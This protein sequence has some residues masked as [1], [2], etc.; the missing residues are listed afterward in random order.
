MTRLLLLLTLAGCEWVRLPVDDGVYDADDDGWYSVD[1]CD[2]FNDNVHPLAPEKCNGTDNNCSG[3]EDDAEDATTWYADLDGDGYGDAS[4]ALPSCDVP[5]GYVENP[6][7]CDDSTPA[8]HPGA[9]E[10]DCTD[11]VDYDCD[12]FPA[13]WDSDQDGSPDCEDCDEDDPTA[14]PGA[15]E[16]CNGID[17]D[18]D[19]TVDEGEIGTTWYLDADGDG[20]GHP[21][22]SVQACER[23]GGY[24]ADATDCDDTDPTE[25]PSAP[26]ACDGIDNDCDGTVDEPDRFGNDRWY[27]DTDGDGYGDAGSWIGSC[28]PVDGY[29]A[30][31]TDCDDADAA[32][33]PGT[34]ELCDS[35]DQDC[36]GT[37]DEDAV[38]APAWYRDADR[39]RWGADDNISYGCSQPSGYIATPG[40][41]DDGDRT[42]SP[43]AAEECGGG[44]EDCDGATDEEGAVGGE[45]WY[46]DVDGDGYGDDDGAVQS[47]SEPAGMIAVPGDCD[48][49]DAIVHPDALEID[50]SDPT[51][52]NCDG[53][54]GSDDLDGDGWAACEDCDDAD[55]AR[56][57]DAEETCDG[58][59]ED[60]DGDVDEDAVDATG[61]Y[62]D[63]DGDGYGEVGADL[64]MMCTPTGGYA[65]VDGDCDDADAA[66]SPGATETCAT[67]AD[68][69]CD[70][71]TNLDGLGC[72]DWFVD[73]DGDGYGGEDGLCLCEAED[74]YVAA[75]SLDCADDDGAV[76]PDAAEVCGNDEDDDCDG[77]AEGCGVAGLMA[78]AD[79]DARFV[80]Q[81]A[82]DELG[83]AIVAPGDLD[84]DGVAEVIVSAPGEDGTGTDQGAIHLFEAPF[85]GD[86][87]TRAA[88]ERWLGETDSDAAGDALV[89]GD[90]DGD[91]DVDLVVG[92]PQD[93]LMGS[94]A[95]AIFIVRGPLAGT[96]ASLASADMVSRG[97]DASDSA[98]TSL[99]IVDDADADGDVELAVGAFRES[100]WSGGAGVVYVFGSFLT[101]YSLESGADA[102]LSGLAS[103]DFFGR[104]VA[105]GGDLDGD[106]LGDLLVGAY[107]DDTGGSNAGAAYVFLGTLSASRTAADADAVRYGAARA[108]AAGY[109]V[110]G[111]GDIDGDGYHDFVVGAFNND[112]A[113]S[114]AGAA[115]V[116]F[117]PVTGSEALGGGATL[118][119]AATSDT[120]GTALAL[121]DLDDDGFADVAVA[122]DGTTWG[123]VGAVSVAYGPIS[124]V[125]SLTDAQASLYGEDTT[126]GVGASLVIGEDLDGDG[127]PELFV[128]ATSEDTTAT[129][130]GAV[131]VVPGGP[132]L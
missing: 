113:G 12:G 1:D 11:P 90:L 119:G 122:S 120:A 95:G 61:W 102:V 73:A 55:A 34:D 35:V 126:D 128:G 124:G 62:P 31:G 47:C 53:S 91:G 80:G 6:F 42:V 89:V 106:G 69:D 72:T 114:N 49:A 99:A 10:E 52:Y 104:S 100:S 92:A 130:A 79:V 125:S 26:E 8:I 84:G 33:H 27:A 3:S 78:L 56:S 25:H 19:G 37:V 129:D 60:C 107:A 5:L 21:A 75:T 24:S 97:T 109:A 18:C 68:D 22:I 28:V 45:L 116:V 16:A 40:D 87:E 17:D 85:S 20:W 4:T 39:D 9:R 93:D 131:Y 50:C 88:S 13:S 66:V 103:G 59:D 46:P 94:A 96:A 121:G 14:H 29:L 74:P 118:L 105:N 44:D 54:V 98:G 57:P 83:T 36:D 63:A 82:S 77:Y 117:G 67:A 51:D 132:G 65:A 81:S 23:P 48:D 86:V 112:D 70:G 110:A 58:A 2:D 127:Y 7:D 115:Y 111:G 76:N 71:E 38:D 32:I 15:V 41:C 123:G 43:S 30:E 64:T 108:D 101:D